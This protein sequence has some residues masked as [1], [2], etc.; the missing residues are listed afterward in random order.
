MARQAR[1]DA[2]GA[3]HYIIICEELG[4]VMAIRDQA[5]MLWSLRSYLLRRQRQPHI[6]RRYF[7]EEH[8][9]YPAT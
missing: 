4:F 7:H 8:V 6:V 5:Q 1:I 2:F 3:V 9:R